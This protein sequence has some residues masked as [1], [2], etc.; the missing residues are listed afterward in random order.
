[1]Q[2]HESG[3]IWCPNAKVG[4]SSVIDAFGLGRD[5]GGFGHT[6]VQGQNSSWRKAQDMTFD[7]AK[8]VRRAPE[9][10]PISAS[11]PPPP[12]PASALPIA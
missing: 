8:E 1:M 4:S 12:P 2:V 6:G 3:L 7:E 10:T 9:H 11:R 5:K